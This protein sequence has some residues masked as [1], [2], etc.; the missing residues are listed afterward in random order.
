MV[1]L[2]FCIKAYTEAVHHQANTI[3]TIRNFQETSMVLFTVCVMIILKPK[4]YPGLSVS[5]LHNSIQILNMME[6]SAVLGHGCF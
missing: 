4:Q 1:F 2:H 6:I 5:Y 3:Y